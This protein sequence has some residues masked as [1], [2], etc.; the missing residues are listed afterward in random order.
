MKLDEETQR[1]F[2]DI[3]HYLSYSFGHYAQKEGVAASEK[4]KEL[5][6]LVE[7]ANDVK[8]TQDV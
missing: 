4:L 2:D 5:V 8:A 7:K 1:M 6:T 3:Q